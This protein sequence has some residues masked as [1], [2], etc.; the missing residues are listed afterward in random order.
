MTGQI[1]VMLGGDP[2]C[3]TRVRNQ[4]NRTSD[5]F[6]PIFRKLVTGTGNGWSVFL[7]LAY[8][9]RYR[10]REGSA[11]LHTWGDWKYISKWPQHWQ[12]LLGELEDGD[13]G[14][15]KQ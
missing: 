3:W 10:V 15:T 9:I 14:E 4:E 6:A 2:E 12:P 7:G 11:W 5:R 1:D 8:T 13:G